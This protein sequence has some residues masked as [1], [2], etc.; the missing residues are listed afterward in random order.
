MNQKDYGSKHRKSKNKI[1]IQHF[2][3]IDIL[4]SQQINYE[5]FYP[6]IT[7]I[8]KTMFRLTHMVNISQVNIH[9]TSLKWTDAFD[10]NH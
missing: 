10:H 9:T 1:T 2:L 3:T 6:F 7:D 5:V 4:I 8:T